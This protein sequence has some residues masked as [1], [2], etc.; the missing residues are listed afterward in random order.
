MPYAL[1]SFVKVEASLRQTFLVIVEST[2]KAYSPVI[3]KKPSTKH[4]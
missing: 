3:M 4:N 1:Y 2:A